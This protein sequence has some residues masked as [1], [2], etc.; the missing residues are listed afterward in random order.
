M[1]KRNMV[2]LEIKS[3]DG[4]WTNNLYVPACQ[5][6]PNVRGEHIIVTN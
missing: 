6:T 1:Q 2:H 4:R 5:K 3:I